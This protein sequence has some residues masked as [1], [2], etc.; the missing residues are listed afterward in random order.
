MTHRV[1]LDGE[2]FA[3]LN[4][5]RINNSDSPVST[6]RKIAGEPSALPIMRIDMT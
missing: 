4:I 2:L 1:S 6:E 3:Q 5:A